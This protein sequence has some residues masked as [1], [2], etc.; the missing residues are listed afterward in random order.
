MLL[1]K[2]DLDAIPDRL[3]PFN[4]SQWQTDASHALHAW[5]GLDDQ[6]ISFH[7]EI[8]LWWAFPGPPRQNRPLSAFVRRVNRLGT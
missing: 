6:P 4:G 5:F 7:S 2:R 8:G 1:K 3:D